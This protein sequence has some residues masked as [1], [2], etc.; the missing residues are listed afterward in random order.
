M[1]DTHDLR[2]YLELALE[3]LDRGCEREA[4][5]IIRLAAIEDIQ[6]AFAHGAILLLHP[7]EERRLQAKRDLYAILYQEPNQ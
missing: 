3:Q 1:S 7:E 2:R 4:K 6:S 5:N